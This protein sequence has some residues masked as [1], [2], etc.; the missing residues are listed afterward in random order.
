MKVD[1]QSREATIEDTKAMVVVLK[2]S[3]QESCILDH[4]NDASLIESW[5]SNK[6]EAQ[7]KRW[8]KCQSLFLNV[9][10]LDG[11]IAGVG[12]VTTAGEISLCYVSP[13]FLRRGVGAAVINGLESHLVG[14][15]VTR[16]VL[17]RTMGS[18]QLS[19]S[20]GYEISG[21]PM[22]I[23]GITGTPMRR[24]LD[25]ASNPGHA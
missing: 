7:L 2:S 6:T 8:I 15:G 11:Q 23:Q 13:D 12:I 10:T 9:V 5:L 4:A 22:I 21:N 18:V 17:T 20:M 19:L 16:S 14:I 25:Q 3:I 24:G 1:I